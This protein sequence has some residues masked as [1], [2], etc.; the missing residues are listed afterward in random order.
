MSL[1][2]IKNVFEAKSFLSN[3]FAFLLTIN[4][5][6][7]FII[8]DK[9]S[10]PPWFPSH[11]DILNIAFFAGTEQPVD[12]EQPVVSEQ[13]DSEPPIVMEHSVGEQSE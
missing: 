13:E 5:W 1:L 3:L 11:S 2:K 7:A 4:A 8:T 12:I 10:L 6:I 9:T